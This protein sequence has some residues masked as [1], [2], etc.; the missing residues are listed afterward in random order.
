MD[1][2]E[3]ALSQLR[4]MIAHGGIGDDGRLPP[5]RDLAGELGVGRRSLRRALGVLAEEGQIWRRQGQGT[6]V[7]DAKAPSDL[8]LG[9]ITEHTNP[10]EIMEVR[11]A[12]E[13]VM[14]RLAAIRA[15]RCDIERLTRLAEET[16]AAPDAARYEKANDAFHR[17]I[18][19]AARNALFLTLL[20][21]VTE[22]LRGLAC[23]RLGESAHC[24][25]RQAVHADFHG[26]IV[27][28][29]AGRD[30]E[31]AEQIMY[32]HLRDVQQSILS[33]AFPAASGGPPAAG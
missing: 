4:E 10:M 11:L 6:F 32:A 18:A 28:A 1:R 21:A 24:Y 2:H 12:I 14:A 17:R 3:S 22:M 19:E 15:S 31:R 33:R 13:P 25:K 7:R 23:E 20:D 30:G 29:I 27:G 16:R 9:R 5:E 8:R 26:E